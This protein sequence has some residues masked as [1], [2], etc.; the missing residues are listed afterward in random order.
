MSK[1]VN[2]DAVIDEIE[3]H[4]QYMRDKMPNEK[5][6]ELYFLAHEHIKEL[7]LLKVPSA[8]EESFEWCDGCKEYDQEKHCCHRY[9]KVIRQAVAE[10]KLVHCID[11]QHSEY[12]E[13]YKDRYCHYNGKAEVVDDYHYC[14]D[15]EKREDIDEMPTVETPKIRGQ[16][17]IKG[18]AIDTVRGYWAKCSACG[19]SVFGGGNYCSYCGSYNEGE[20]ME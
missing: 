5:L 6:A 14:R 11:C 15:G 19:H 18:Q 7:I 17:S 12:D 1:L 16:W 3:K 20:V 8:E 9:T 10:M 4:K 2:V 13:V